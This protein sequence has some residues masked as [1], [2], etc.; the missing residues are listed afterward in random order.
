MSKETFVNQPPEKPILSVSELT[1]QIKNLLEG[2]FYEIWVGGEISD[3]AR[4][5]SG[6]CYLTLKDDRSQLRAVIWR[7]T[8]SRVK[9][10]IEDGLAV[11]C[12]GHIDVYAP[13]G[14]YQL[15][16]EEIQP[17]GIGAM[18]LAIRQLRDKLT[19]EGLFDKAKKR[20]L[21]KFSRRIAVVTSQTGAAVRDFLEV[22]RRRWQMVDVLIVPVRVQ[23]EGA[24]TEIANAIG[25]VNKLANPVDCIVVTRGGG[26]IED[27]WSFNEE[28]VVRAIHDSKTVVVSAVGHEIDITLSD[29]AADVRAA[30]PSEAAELVA[31]AREEITA[32]L[33]K[34]ERG[35]M[36]AMRGQV[37]SCRAQ[38]DAIKG[39]RVFRRPHQ[40]VHDRARNLD[41][42]EARIHRAMLARRDTDQHHIK[43][44]AARIESLSPLSTLARGYSLTKRTKDGQLIYNVENLSVGDEISTRF[45]KGQEAISRVERIEGR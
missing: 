34:T 20:P 12:R 45:A 11:V 31:P 4:P 21:P 25:T 16:I 36:L 41:E 37:A 1:S 43:S 9:F 14:T 6:H 30:T 18:E 32:E 27:L 23:G 24:A 22:L 42:L 8:A 7:G 33:K 39:D 40:M 13:R 5:Q 35:L 19:K 29:L 26:S 44:I 10:D 28:V 38:L 3:F 17:Q 2:G 15:V